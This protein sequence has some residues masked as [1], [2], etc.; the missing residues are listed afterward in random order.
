MP[1]TRIE[2]RIR[3]PAVL[4]EAA[5]DRA[6]ALGILSLTKYLLSLV[7]RDCGTPERHPGEERGEA[8]TTR[9]DD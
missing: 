6:A 2:V 3:F 4:L 5:Q 7:A 9:Y 1:R 8:D